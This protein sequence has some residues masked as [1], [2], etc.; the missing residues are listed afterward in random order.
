MRAV[1]VIIFSLITIAPVSAQYLPPPRGAV[2][3]L[4]G[5]KELSGYPDCHPDRPYMYQGR[6]V[7]TPMRRVPHVVHPPYHP[8]SRW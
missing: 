8:A 2:P 1:A 3:A 7:A 4:N 5:C 6:N